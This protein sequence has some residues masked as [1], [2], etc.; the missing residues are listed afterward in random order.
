M[1]KHLPQIEIKMITTLFNNIQM[2]GLVPEK[3]KEGNIVMLLKRN[4]ATKMKNYRPITLISV[5]SKLY[6]EIMASRL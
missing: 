1:L 2:L 4:R 5:L 6:T 3:W